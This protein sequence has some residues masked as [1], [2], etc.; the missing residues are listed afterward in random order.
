M[1]AR[2]YVHVVTGQV[3]SGRHSEAL[4]RSPYKKKHIAQLQQKSEA[5]PVAS[6]AGKRVIEQ[7]Y[8]Q[9]S[10]DPDEYDD[11]PEDQLEEMKRL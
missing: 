10:Y 4:A 3:I 11:I 7:Q 9:R 2:V 5:K 6:A 8:Q 1:G